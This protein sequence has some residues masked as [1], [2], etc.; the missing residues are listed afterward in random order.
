MLILVHTVRDGLQPRQPCNRAC[1][2]QRSPAP[3]HTPDVSCLSEYQKHLIC[4]VVLQGTDAAEAVIENRPRKRKI[5]NLA[6]E[7]EFLDRLHRVEKH[8]RKNNLRATFSDQLGRTQALN[9]VASLNEAHQ[10]AFFL[11]WNIKPH[12]D[13]C[14]TVNVRGVMA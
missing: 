1:I 9:D 11:F 4:I 10:L 8:I 5:P 6:D 13:R 2:G 14:D 7:P 3:L 12:F